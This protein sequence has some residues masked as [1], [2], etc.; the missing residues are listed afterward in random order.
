M[1]YL[2]GVD[3]G[4]KKSGNT[5]VAISDGS[6]IFLH[7]V[8]K[9]SDA[10]KR[11]NELLNEFPPDL[12]A[13]DAPLS[14]PLG[15]CG[16]E[17]DLFYRKC[18]MELKAMSPLFLGGLTARAVQFK[19]K[20]EEK[21]IEVIE[22]YPKAFVQNVLNGDYPEAGDKLDDA[23]QKVINAHKL[24]L[25]NL[26][27]NEHQVDAILSLIMAFRFQKGLAYSFG[28]VEEGVIWV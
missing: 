11:L 19:R 15:W 12:V 1:D 9:G 4:A 25:K 22:C 6:K 28:E 3:Y 13:I 8:K 16:G 27:A 17:G 26:P 20:L 18:D 23:L 14:L 21:K 2:W 10:D 24:K 7:Q 5:A